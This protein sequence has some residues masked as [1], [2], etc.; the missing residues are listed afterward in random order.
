MEFAKGVVE[1]M[2]GRLFTKKNEIARGMERGL[3]KA[4][5]FL[6]RES[7]KIVP[8]D[9]G[10]LKN[11]AYTRKTGSGF[12]TT[13]NVG[14]TAEYA[15]YVHENLDAKHKPGKYALFVTTP[16]EAFRDDMI[17]MIRKEALKG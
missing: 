12:S 8:V 15:I 4:G 7:Q 17:A 11:S 2:I 14:Y 13:V 16:A 10:N 6:Q 3:M 5:L 1:T 9:T